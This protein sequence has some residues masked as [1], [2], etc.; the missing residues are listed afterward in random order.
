MADEIKVDT[1]LGQTVDEIEERANFGSVYTHS[2][3]DMRRTILAL[4]AAL[5]QAHRR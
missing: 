5:R 1:P 2:R 4:C 3:H